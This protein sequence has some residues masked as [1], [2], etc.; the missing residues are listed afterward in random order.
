MTQAS[1][2]GRWCAWKKCVGKGLAVLQ[3]LFL[4]FLRLFWGWQFFIAGKGKLTNIQRPAEFFAQIHIPWPLFNAYLVGVTELVG[5]LLLIVGFGARL[6]ALALSI[7]MSVAMATAHRA[8]L[9]Q[10]ISAPDAFLSASAVTFWVASMAI[11][12]FGAGCFSVDACCCRRKCG[13]EANAGGSCC[14]PPP[15]AAQ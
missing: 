10:I 13:Q 3:P 5:G 4:L 7:A 15:P 6:A 14:A 9:V 2:S 11:L 12:C 1:C 8:E